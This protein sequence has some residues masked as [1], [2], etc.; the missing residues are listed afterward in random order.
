MQVR[1]PGSNRRAENV[2]LG[3]L[4]E[5]LGPSPALMC[6][7]VLAIRQ[8]LPF[9]LNNSSHS[10]HCT[11]ILIV[12]LTRVAE[13][14]IFGR[15]VPQPLHDPKRVRRFLLSEPAVQ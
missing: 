7:P 2:D 11:Y 5:N 9:S 13:V 15:P 1:T 4:L 8:L 6:F 14:V 10:R 12:I 3:Q